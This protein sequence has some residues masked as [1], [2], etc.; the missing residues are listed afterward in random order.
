M[1]K[2]EHQDRG[3]EA[4]RLGN[5]GAIAGGAITILGGLLL[6]MFGIFVIGA[7]FHSP[8]DILIPLS[9]AI[10]SGSALAMIGG[11]DAILSRYYLRA[12]V[13]STMPAIFFLGGFAMA[14]IGD[15]GSWT[16]FLP[17]GVMGALGA[18]L[19]AA[20]RGAF[21]DSG[22]DNRAE[23]EEA[24]K[25]RLV[26]GTW[27][28]VAA[29]AI[30]ILSIVMIAELIPDSFSEATCFLVPLLVGMI[31]LLSYILRLRLS[32]WRKLGN[33]DSERSE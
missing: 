33:R 27:W 11:F 26:K 29:A 18:F 24:W 16:V 25:K 22:S 21:L 13:G 4:H 19:V 8:K 3:P 31:F 9:A 14:N 5:W 30:L 10:L 1:A 6:A 32:Y 17:P 7:Y 2:L 15:P 20:S 12:L 28:V 23:I